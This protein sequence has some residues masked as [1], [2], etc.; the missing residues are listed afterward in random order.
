MASGRRLVR[1]PG[2]TS[3]GV[4][5]TRLQ[6][7]PTAPRGEHRSSRL[8]G[9]LEPEDDGA[10]GVAADRPGECCG[11]IGEAVGGRDRDRQRA[12]GEVLCQR[13]QLVPVRAD[14]DVGDRDAPLLGG[15][16]RCDRGQPPVVRD[17]AKGVGGMA[18]DR[19]DRGCHAAAL[20]D[21][22][23]LFGPVPVV[24]VDVAAL[25]F[26]D[27]S[28]LRAVVLAGRH[29]AD[30]ERRLVLVRGSSPVQRIFEITRMTERLEFV[31]APEHALN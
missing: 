7:S 13:A 30:N 23:N 19:V 28:G 6:P 31:D 20:R 2:P 1:F 16:I 22:A 21:L 15:R 9:A 10:P 3:P 4:M 8:G 12:G 29:L 5:P 25:D 27:S 11:S 18:G 17:R 26:L 24:V 14:V